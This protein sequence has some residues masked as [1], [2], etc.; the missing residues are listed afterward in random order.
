MFDKFEFFFREIYQVGDDLLWRMRPVE[1][2]S[3][4]AGMLP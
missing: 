4:I 1:L 2:L 3:K